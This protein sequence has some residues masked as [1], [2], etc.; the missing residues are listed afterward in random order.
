MK[1]ISRALG[2]IYLAVLVCALVFG[3]VGGSGIRET[4]LDTGASAGASFVTAVAMI[5]YFAVIIAMVVITV[6]QI[7][8]R[9]HKNMFGGE[10][11]LMHTLPVP[12]WMHV[13][14]KTIAALIWI[15]CGF[16]TVI[17]SGVLALVSSGALR[18]GESFS[19]LWNAISMFF[20]SVNLPGV[21]TAVLLL[22][23]LVAFVLLIYFCMAAGSMANRHKVAMS[24][25]TFVGV[26]LLQAVVSW[27]VQ[28]TLIS[29]LY[30]RQEIFIDYSSEEGLSLMHDVLVGAEIRSLILYLV[31]CVVFFAGTSYIMKK[32]LNLE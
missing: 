21:L 29:T 11:Y 32:R 2:G 4:G 9:F 8:G 28:H 7:I 31:Y 23:E 12:A 3:L 5:V 17:L 18:T 6:I 10:G 16:V 15:V 27:I 13:A 14:S 22:A 1:A 26:M 25:L 19:S 24:L 30:P 20:D